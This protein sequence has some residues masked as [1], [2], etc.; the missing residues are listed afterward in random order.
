MPTSETLQLQQFFGL[1][2]G[3][4]CRF[5][6]PTFCGPVRL[7]PVSG[8]Y[9]RTRRSRSTDF[10]YSGRT[11]ADRDA[12]AALYIT[13]ILSRSVALDSIRW[14][15][16]GDFAPDE[17]GTVFLFGSRSNQA[18]EW[19]TRESALGRFFQFE[20]ASE[21]SIRVGKRLFSLPAPDKLS[22]EAYEQET[23]YGVIGRFKDL[24]TENH[25][26]L[27]AGLGSRAT[28]GSAYYLTHR[29]LSLAQRFVN[30]DFAIILMFPPP[31]DPKNSHVV[32][33]LS[34]QNR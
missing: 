1:N 16:T 24:R 22:R 18:S 21:W 11:F 14:E 19:V 12:K 29:W 33:E 23:D 25:V 8:R 15:K 28:E 10:R 32:A 20:F 34:D 7:E 17:P 3:E 13:S 5:Y 9:F 26:F 27:V 6:L 4:P 31:I 2:S 30:K